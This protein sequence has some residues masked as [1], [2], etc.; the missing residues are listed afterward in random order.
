MASWTAASEFLVTHAR[1]LERRRLLGDAEAVR[2]AVLAYR[3][4]DGGFGHAIEADVRSPHSQPLGC[5]AAMKP[6]VEVGLGDVDLVPTCDWLA[7]LGDPA[8][9]ILLPTINGYP[10]AGHWGDGPYEPHVNPT[11]SLAGYLHALGVRHPWVDDATAWCWT[12][13]EN[14]PPAEAHALKCALVFLEHVPDRDR[15]ERLAPTMVDAL[16]GSD[17]FRADP[18]APEYGVTPLDVADRPDHPWAPLFDDLD[19]HLDRLERDQLG[20][21]GWP[22]TW[23]APGATSV[24]EWRGVVTL[25]AVHVLRAFGR[26]TPG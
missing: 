14:G 1:P 23:D 16:R 3:N 5:E 15:A 6:L 18:D 4:P 20:D 19:A 11:A 25:H 21:G 10:K 24:T 13:L 22:V 8:V 7:S 9:P 12:A 17:W 2:H 26:L